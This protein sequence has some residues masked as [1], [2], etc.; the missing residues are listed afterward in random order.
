MRALRATLLV[1]I[2]GVLGGCAGTGAPAAITLSPS[3]PVQVNAPLTI[4]AEVL[5]SKA[6]VTWAL[7]GPGSLSALVGKQVVYR[8]P[9]PI[10]ADLS[11]TVTATVETASA[12]I[13]LT[14]GA[15]VLTGAKIPGLTGAVTV[16]YDAYDIPHI[17]CAAA[18]DCFAVQGWVHAHDR[19]FPMDFLR[20]VARGRLS[21]L[22]GVVGLDQDLQLRTLF[23]TRDGQRLEDALAAGTDADTKVKVDAYVAGINAYLNELRANPTA[24]LPGEYGQLPYTITAAD[25]PLWTVADVW[26]LARLQQFQLSES[27]GAEQD[28]GIFAAVYGPG[29]PLQ[30]FGK[31]NSYIRAA[32]PAAGQTHT[33]PVA[34]THDPHSSKLQK[35]AAPVSPGLSGWTKALQRT[36]ASF[37]KLREALKPLGETVGSNNWVVDAAHSASGHAMV[38][39]DPH[40]SLQ[41]P[42]LFH[43]AALTSSKASDNL[44]VTGGAFPGIPGALVGRGKN[45]GWGVTVVGYDVTDLY[46]EQAIP[47]ANCATKPVNYA[48]CVLFNGGP[49]AVLAYPQSFKVRVAAGSADSSF[50]EGSTLGAP[51]FVA[52]VPHHGPIVA[53]PDE[54]TGRAVSLRWTGQES[55]TQDLKAFLGLAT[56]ANVDEAILALKNYS[57]GAQNFVLADDQGNIAFDPHALV[58]VRNFA[59]IREVGGDVQPPWFPLP[60]DGTAEWGTGVASD[61]CAGT[62]TNQP[63]AACW[64]ADAELPQGKN[65]AKGFYATANSDPLGVSD[66]NSPLSHPP[67]LSFEWDDSTGLRHAQVTKRLTALTTAG[68]KASLADMMSMQADHVSTLGAIFQGILA[69]YPTMPAPEFEAARAM[70]AQWKANGFDCPTGLIGT[71]PVTATDDPDAVQAAN[72]ASCMLFH[73]FLRTLIQSVF[74]DDLAV[75]GLSIATVPAVKGM[76]HMLDPAAPAGDKSFCND[77][78][79]SGETLQEHSCTAQV[80]VA[81]VTAYDLLTAQH[82]ATMHWRWGR[83]HTMQPISQLALV[84]DGYE[85]GPFA[86]PGGAFTV[87]VAAPRLGQAGL[88][89][90]AYRSSGNVRH[91]SVMDPTAPI[92]KMQLPGP[93]RDGPAGLIEGPDLLGGWVRNQY[94]DFAVGGQV[95]PS[96]VATQSFS[97]P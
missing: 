97:A 10:G 21:E 4:T 24:K 6:T 70:F 19:L 1:L 91:I 34:G 95:G 12:S 11:A 63:A 69:N 39:N 29:G 28:Y 79:A 65:P 22:I 17:A 93:E 86:R 82:G 38:A 80:V 64:I 30:D 48:F 44:D 58:P 37:A 8:P 96:T 32:S 84:T 20:R 23:T 78:D 9:S 41:Y 26:A 50:I 46:L 62:G 15:T 77:V 31:L 49:V 45:V 14:L 87:D 5:Y 2:G 94:F 56:A 76:I 81:M 92:V 47:D 89:T 18:V 72:S 88:S 85:P 90:F 59:D 68:G 73:A 40:L 27:L 55:A 51:A 52:I 74:T 53:A 57:T 13:T 7:T 43:L 60:G 16:S 36:Y 3:V 75:A 66:D 83:V 67:Y 42:P 71:D 33:L 54:T 25:I 61:H 35:A